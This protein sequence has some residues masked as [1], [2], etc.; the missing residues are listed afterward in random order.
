MSAPVFPHNQFTGKLINVTKRTPFSVEKY[1]VLKSV[2]TLSTELL[3]R[4]NNRP[5]R[6]PARC[7]RATSQI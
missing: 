3:R 6:L 7:R 1:E 5:T 4:V 2:H